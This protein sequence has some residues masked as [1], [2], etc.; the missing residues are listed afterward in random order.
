MATTAI[1]TS[2]KATRE[3]LGWSR[4]T[5][6]HRSGVS[7]A[8]ISQIESGRRSDV[9]LSTLSALAR[10]LGVSIDYLSGH[11]ASAPPPMLEHRGLLYGSDEELLAAVA[12][13]LRD[14][15]ERSEGML[16]V[17]SA[18][19]MELIRDELGDDAGSIEL[20]NAAD[21]SSSRV[22]A[23]RRFRDFV[24]EQLEAG[25]NWVRMVS[26]PLW[27]GDIAADIWE[28]SRFESLVNL[29]LAAAPATVLCSY[30]TRSVPANVVADVW[31]THPVCEQA[32]ASA[33]SPSYQDPREFLLRSD[34]R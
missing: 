24:D 26:E 33:A 29:T 27:N 11:A 15:I 5:L 1:G 10:A 8:A 13:F 12:P 3:R 17:T 32:G 21:W 34:G 22:D 23:L 2:L 28:W 7:W 4:E 6:A 31:R 20:A 14:G 16:A 18:S 25:S 30:D 9:R 19:A